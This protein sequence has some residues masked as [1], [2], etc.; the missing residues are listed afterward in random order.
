MLDGLY[1]DQTVETGRVADTDGHVFGLQFK[2]GQRSDLQF[3]C[4]ADDGAHRRSGGRALIES[5]VRS[6]I[7]T[8]LDAGERQGTVGQHRSVERIKKES[9]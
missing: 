5:L 9:K 2:S 8:V 3:G 1:H 7:T 4:P 6:L